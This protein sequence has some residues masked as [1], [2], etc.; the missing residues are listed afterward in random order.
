MIPGTQEYM[1]PDENE[2][3]D[4]GD[5]CD[6]RKGEVPEDNEGDKVSPSKKLVHFM[7]ED[8]VVKG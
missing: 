1:K 8:P 3:E 6:K 4:A 7:V 5:E 2:P